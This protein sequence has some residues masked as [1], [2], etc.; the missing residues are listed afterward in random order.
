M[1][2]PDEMIYHRGKYYTKPNW[3]L[4]DLVPDYITPYKDVVNNLKYTC[5]FT[6][7][8]IPN[9]I[10]EYEHIVHEGYEKYGKEDIIFMLDDQMKESDIVIIYAWDYDDNE[11]HKYNTILTMYNGEIQN[12]GKETYFPLEK[13]NINY[14]YPLT[15]YVNQ[16]KLIIRPIGYLIDYQKQIDDIPPKMFSRNLPQ[17][18]R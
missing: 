10:V 16:S 18:K 14:F 3:K 8:D 1:V 17:K 12:Y 2:Y 9:F 11:E 15:R 6:S 13:Y 5:G 7:C 4:Y